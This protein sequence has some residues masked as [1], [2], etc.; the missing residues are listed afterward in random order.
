MINRLENLRNER[1][2]EKKFNQ[3][4]GNVMSFFSIKFE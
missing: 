1:D 2:F 3:I 4:E